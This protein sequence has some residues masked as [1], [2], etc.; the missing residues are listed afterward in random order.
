AKQGDALRD[1]LS[2]EEQDDCEGEAGEG[3][4]GEG[5]HGSGSRREIGCL[6]G[7]VEPELRSE[8]CRVRRLSGR[9]AP[10]SQIR[11]RVTSRAGRCEVMPRRSN[12]RPVFWWSAAA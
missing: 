8:L 3:G 5:G 10:D 11:Q 9:S 4:D 2:D 12:G 1:V 6:R 7:S